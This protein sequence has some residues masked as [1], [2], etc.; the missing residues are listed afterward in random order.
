M[1]QFYARLFFIFSFA[2]NSSVFAQH[3]STL[4]SPLPAAL[5]ISYHGNNLWNPGLNIGLEQSRALKQKVNRKQRTL[6]IETYF[7]ADLGIFRDYSRQTPLFSHLGINKRRYRKDKGG[8]HYQF[9]FSPLGVYRSFLPETWEYTANGT[10]EKVT[11]PGR[12]YY[13]PVM[14]FGMGKFHQGKPGTGWFVEINITTLMPYNTYIMPLLNIKAGYRIPMKKQ[15]LKTR[16][17]P[18]ANEPI[19]N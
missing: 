6:I 12:W 16:A 5:N 7:N 13:A 8:F 2:Y 14:S 19:D 1:N 4:S 15:I 11:F 3:Q 17:R 10:V 9:G 18:T